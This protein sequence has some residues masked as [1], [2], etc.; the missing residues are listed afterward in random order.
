[1]RARVRIPPVWILH[2]KTRLAARIVTR[3]REA[4]TDPTIHQPMPWS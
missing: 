3:G 4:S 2:R 1:M